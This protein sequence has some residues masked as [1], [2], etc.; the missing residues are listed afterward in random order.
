[1][2]HCP[3]CSTELVARYDVQICPRN[4]IGDCYFDGYEQYQ[5]EYHQLKNNQQDSTF[6]IADIVADQQA[7]A[8]V[9]NLLTYLP[10]SKAV[11]S[12]TPAMNYFSN[13]ETRP[14][15]MSP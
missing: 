11:V 3:S 12:E 4:E 1:M 5:L 7:K 14:V 6:D 10:I 15:Q 13:I 8:L 2:K 9:G